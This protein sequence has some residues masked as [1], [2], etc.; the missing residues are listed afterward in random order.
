MTYQPAKRAN[1]EEHTEHLDAWRE[2]GIEAA[3]RESCHAYLG[4]LDSLFVY[5]RESVRIA[6][7]D[8]R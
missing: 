6:E 8:D 3:R 4:F 5:H 2:Q 1:N 7:M